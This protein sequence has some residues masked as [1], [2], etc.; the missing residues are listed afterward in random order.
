MEFDVHVSMLLPQSTP[1]S[2]LTA[3][4]YYEYWTL[5]E[6]LHQNYVK[7]DASGFTD[8]SSIAVCQDAIHMQP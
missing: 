8:Q 1:Q 4:A 2:S 5:I 3:A 6:L 7:G